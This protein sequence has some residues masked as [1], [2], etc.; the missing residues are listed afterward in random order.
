MSG[1]FLAM[2]VGCQVLWCSW[3]ILAHDV[4]NELVGGSLILLSGANLACYVLRHLDLL[5]SRIADR[6]LF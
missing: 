2:G 4:S 3:G 6:E 1:V 5:G